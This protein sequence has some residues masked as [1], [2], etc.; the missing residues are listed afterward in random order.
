MKFDPAA[1][2]LAERNLREASHLLGDAASATNAANLHM[3]FLNS[4]LA[5]QA[6]SAAFQ[7]IGMGQ[8]ADKL[9][10]ASRYIPKQAPR[11]RT[12][13]MK[14]RGYRYF[15]RLANLKYS[16]VSDIDTLETLLDMEVESATGGKSNDYGNIDQAII[17]AARAYDAK[18][19]SILKAW[20]SKNMAKLDLEQGPLARAK[21][22]DDVVSVMMELR[23]GA[24][25]LYFMEAEGAGVGTWDGDWD[26]MFK[27][28]KKT[29]DELSK[30]V[31]K[32]AQ[33]QYR[34]LKQAL[35]N[36]AL[37]LVP[38]EDMGQ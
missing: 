23:G 2:E 31:K 4:A 6:V 9:Q 18:V 33:V 10:D 28:S 19:Q 13:S 1:A 38:E 35:E 16:T 29:I 8:A 21:K 27:D 37:E 7:N 17:T 36:R 3:M 32:Q 5:V 22:P 20:V 12:T 11:S 34:K 24:G 25:Y 26:P 30:L 15:V 14:T